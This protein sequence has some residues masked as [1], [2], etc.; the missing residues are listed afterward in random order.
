M[1]IEYPELPVVF[2][3]GPTASGKTALAMELY[4]TEKFEIISVDSAMVYQQMDIGS[5][6]PTAEEL[7][8]A[9]HHL[10]DFID[11]GQAYSASQFVQDSKRLIN[12]VH[13]MGKTPLLTGGTMLYFKALK[14]GL[15]ELPQSDPQVRANLKKHLDEQGIEY[16]HE[17]LSEVDQL[18]AER[19]HTNDTQR[20]MRALEVYEISGKPMSQW[21][22][23]QAL[24]A[25]PN[26]LLSVALAPQDRSILH[27]RI[28][29]RFHLMIKQGL[30][31]EVTQLYQRG[32]LS[33]DCPSMKSVGYRQVWQYLAGELS[34]EE[35]IERGIIATRQLAKR[36]YT[37]LRSW[38]DVKW[39]DP[40][41]LEQTKL[42]K[43]AIIRHS[44][45]G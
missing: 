22:Q 37:W 43:D 9:P 13:A 19:L 28:A 2:L 40:T 45:N 36:Q 31:E 7:K 11:P 16:L 15:A 1:K 33:L 38:P 12:Q 8:L 26:P 20:I 23:E 18:T 17:K 4:Q 25:L 39:F 24:D 44:L 6:K 10:I 35:A 27:Q 21:H 42:A 3:M 5:A 30:I 34:K 29:E 41:V 32:D 14:E